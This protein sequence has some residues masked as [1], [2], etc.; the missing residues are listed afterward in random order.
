METIW[1]A[2]ARR[3]QRNPTAIAISGAANYSY[4]EL[5]ERAEAVAHT[6]QDSC[7]PGSLVALDATSPVAGAIAFLAAGKARCALLPLNSESPTR[8]RA[9]LLADACA[10]LMLT[11]GAGNS[12]N[13]NSVGQD[14]AATVTRWP[15]SMLKVAYVIYT[16]G[17]TGRPKGVAVSH[18]ALLGRLRSLARV[19][20]LRPTESFLAMTALSFD[21]SVAE[22]LLPLLTGARMIASPA[23][24]RLDPAVFA[25]VVDRYRPSVIQATPSFWRLA[26]A[27]GWSGLQGCRLW[28]GGEPLTPSLAD[29]LLRSGSE[30]WNVYGPTEATIWASAARIR[31]SDAIGLGT[32]L[33]GT[34][35]CL[36][37]ENDQLVTSYGQ[38]GQILL[39]GDGLALGY[40]NQP[41]LTASLFRIHQTPDGPKP[42]YRT[43]DRAR[44]RS[45][46]V[47]EFIGRHDNQVKLRGHRIELGELEAI[48]E[49]HP[50]VHEAAAVLRDSTNPQKAHIAVF[51]A[52]DTSLTSNQL[53]AWLRERLPPSMR[54]AHIDVRPGL[55]LTTAGKIDRLA[56]ANDPI[57][58]QPPA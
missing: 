24:T 47:L 34:G 8:H 9:A 13:M 45:D 11:E 22:L 56:L 15:P 18:Q 48:A 40:V 53:R 12:L 3:A 20:G 19:P 25:A 39:Y 2:F 42:C 30:L 32:P 58:A 54:P 46:G 35:L 31:S 7:K 27:W 21:I 43:G 10:D 41:G 44:Y 26:L 38:P 55:P 4:A 1:D 51:V 52:G 36:V 50:S 49:E 29:R 23:T 5:L 57:D 28:C 37:D 33:P 16:S 6:L 17:S 14:A